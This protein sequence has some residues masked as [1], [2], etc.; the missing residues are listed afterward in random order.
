MWSDIRAHSRSMLSTG[1]MEGGLDAAFFLFP[2]Y[3][4]FH[5]VYVMEFGFLLPYFGLSQ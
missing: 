1:E 2:K 4:F 5:M 3:C